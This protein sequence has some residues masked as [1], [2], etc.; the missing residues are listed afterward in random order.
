M[1]RSLFAIAIAGFSVLAIPASADTGRDLVA[2]CGQSAS[3]CGSDFQS[4]QLARAM[5]ASACMPA[6]SGKAQADVVDYLGKHPKT[7]GLEIEKAVAI[8]VRALW[9]C[10]K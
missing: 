2:V 4:D 5:K 10:R 9:P 6:D 7:A 3:L 1:T 8:A